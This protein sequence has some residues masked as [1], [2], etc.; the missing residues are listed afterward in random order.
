MLPTFI[1]LRCRR[2]TCW[3]SLSSIAAPGLRKTKNRNS[4]SSIKVLYPAFPSGSQALSVGWGKG[5]DHHLADGSMCSF[6]AK[7]PVMWS[8]GV[9]LERKEGK[10][11][12]FQTMQVPPPCF[13]LLLGTRVLAVFFPPL[14]PAVCDERNNRL[15]GS[16]CNKG[17]WGWRKA[18]TLL[19]VDLLSSPQLARDMVSMTC[20]SL[21]WSLCRRDDSSF[22]NAVRIWDKNLM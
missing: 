3:E 16:K 1:Q 21:P 13:L 6:R 22:C 14:S 18:P 9:G 15:G 5:L 20:S 11:N 17:C 12:P 19:Q 7:V 2:A 4:L 10:A 8:F